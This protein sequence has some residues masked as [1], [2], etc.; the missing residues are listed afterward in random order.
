MKFA[1]HIIV[2]KFV[3]DCNETR[4]YSHVGGPFIQIKRVLYKVWR[5]MRQFLYEFRLYH[6]FKKGYMIEM[7]EN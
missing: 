1:Y 5:K 3:S 4:V 7:E 6:P 2:D